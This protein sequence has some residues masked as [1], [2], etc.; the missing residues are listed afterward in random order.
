VPSYEEVRLLDGLPRFVSSATQETHR[1]A[2][3][4][5][6]LFEYLALACLAIWLAGCGG[7]AM[8]TVEGKVTY[9]GKPVNDATIQFQSLE[10]FLKACLHTR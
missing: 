5:S 3:R 4:R 6:C 7:R 10:I 1:M 9:K 8:G 2:F